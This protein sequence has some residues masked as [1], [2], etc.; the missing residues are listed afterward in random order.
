MMLVLPNIIFIDPALDLSYYLHVESIVDET[1]QKF[2]E[3]KKG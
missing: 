3:T 1:D 2:R